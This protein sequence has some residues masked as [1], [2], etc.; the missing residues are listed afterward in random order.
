MKNILIGLAL[1]VVTLSFTTENGKLSGLVTY[2]DSYES[3]NQ[4]DAGGEIYAIS[5]AD[6]RSAQYGDVAKV[7]GRFM[8]SKSDYS[9]AVFNT[10]DPGRV[11]QAQDYFDTVSEITAK[12]ITRFKKLP[13]VAR[14]SANGKGN[15]TLNLM[16][17]KYYVLFISGTVKSDNSVESKGNVDIKVIDVKPAGETMLDEIFKIHENFSLMFLTGRYLQGC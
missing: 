6:A 8:M 17:G 5:Q 14:A 16:P 15:Y 3:S 11:K 4:A 12:Y 2:K 9:Q 10:V 1:L 7:I 13:A